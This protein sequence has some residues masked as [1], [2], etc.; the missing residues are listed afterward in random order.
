MEFTKLRFAFTRCRDHPQ[1]AGEIQLSEIALFGGD[2]GATPVPI[3]G[4]TNPGGWAPLPALR[5]YFATPAF[6]FGILHQYRHVD[7]INL[8]GLERALA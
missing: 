2:D 5:E 6:H 8:V 7:C 3:L 4:A 1:P